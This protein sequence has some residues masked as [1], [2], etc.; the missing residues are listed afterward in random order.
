MSSVVGVLLL[1]VGVAIGFGF[2]RIYS[3]PSNITVTEHL[4]VTS[5][6]NPTHSSQSDMAEYC[7][8]PG[9]NCADV[10]IRWIQRATDSIHVLM[11]SFTP[12][13]VADAVISAKNRGVDVKI[14][15]ERDN[16]NAAG[17]EY[18]RLKS[19]GV[20]IR[21]DS[22]PNLMHDKIAIIDGH[23]I[24]TGSFNWTASAETHNN[25][26]LVV[27]DNSTWASAFEAQ[28]QQVYAQ[29]IA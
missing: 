16:I 7:F 2:S 11:Y 19:A 6:V 27:L 12:N 21:V 8:S 28:F 10:V 29:A 3:L 13:E 5:V 20:D 1:V 9:G 18:S 4:T 23:F 26:N 15:M 14:V 24:L 22:N 25:E 17:G